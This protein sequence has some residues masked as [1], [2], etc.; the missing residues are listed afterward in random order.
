MDCQQLSKDIL[1]VYDA[2][3]PQK[4]A[5]PFLCFFLPTKLTSTCTCEDEHTFTCLPKAS[6]DA[7]VR[8][9]TRYQIKAQASSKYCVWKKLLHH[10]HQVPHTL[11]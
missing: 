1:K 9:M 10:L 5:I 2:P 11:L 4:M 8:T 7:H 6:G 3:S